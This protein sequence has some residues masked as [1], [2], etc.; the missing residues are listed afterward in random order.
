MEFIYSMNND[1]RIDLS[2]V[3]SYRKY[4]SRNY[5]HPF[6]FKGHMIYEIEFHMISGEWKL[7]TFQL[8]EEWKRSFEV[9]E[10][11]FRPSKI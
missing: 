10:S 7:W 8:E 1:Y 6:D 5:K 9:I 3:E 4:S 2:K 11:L